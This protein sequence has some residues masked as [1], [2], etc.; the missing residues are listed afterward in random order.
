MSKSKKETEMKLK[1]ERAEALERLD[2]NKYRYVCEGC[3]NNAM[4]STN[5]PAGLK[6]T[7]AHCGKEQV[8]KSENFI[9]L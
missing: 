8:T 9:A 5:A 6:I 3:T 4:L 2:S 7:C 1:E